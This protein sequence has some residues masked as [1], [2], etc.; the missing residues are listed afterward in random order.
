VRA[1]R[2][3]LAFLPYLAVLGAL[4]ATGHWYQFWVFAALTVLISD[5]ILVLILRRARATKRQPRPPGPRSSSDYAPMWARKWWLT[6]LVLTG[7]AVAFFVPAFR[8]EPAW[9][10]P[11][12]AIG[13]FVAVGVG[14]RLGARWSLKH[15]EEFERYTH[16][17]ARLGPDG[18]DADPDGGSSEPLR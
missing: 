3:F 1:F 4:A 9:K 14:V 17:R 18:P 6:S 11:V 13:T 16:H 2:L 12:V 7:F 5:S 10:L 15:E 8:G